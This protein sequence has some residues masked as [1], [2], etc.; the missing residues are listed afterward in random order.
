MKK[1]FL[2]LLLLFPSICY[3]QDPKLLSSFDIRVGRLNTDGFNIANRGLSAHIFT[4]SLQQGVMTSCT[5]AFQTSPNNT[6][7]TTQATGDCTS[8]G[9]SSYLSFVG[10]FIRISATT[11][12]VQSGTP[13]LTINYAGYIIPPTSIATITTAPLNNQNINSIRYAAQFSGADAW[14]KIAAAATDLPSTGGTIYAQGLEGSQSGT[15]SISSTKA[16]HLILGSGTYTYSGATV[17]I[18]LGTGSIIEGEGISSTILKVSVDGTDGINPSGNIIIRNL[19]IQGNTSNSPGS[20]GIDG[21]D[22]ANVTID[23]VEVKNWGD[24]GINT[25]NISTNWKILNSDIHDNYND[26]ILLASGVSGMQILGGRMHDNGSMGVDITGPRNQVIGAQIYNNGSRYASLGYDCNGI[27]IASIVSGAYGGS[28][29]HVTIA[30]NIIYDNACKQISSQ[31]T[32]SGT[33]NYLNIRGNTV[34][35]SAGT[36][37]IGINIDTSTGVSCGTS[38]YAVIQGNIVHGFSQQGILVGGGTGTPCIANYT[39]IIGNTVTNNVGVGVYVA[40]GTGAIITNNVILSNTAGNV[41]TGGSTLSVEFCNKTD[42]ATNYCT[43]GTGTLALD[44]IRP[45]T[46][47]GVTVTGTGNVELRLTST[48]AG[49]SDWGWFTD[50]GGTVI[51]RDYTNSANRLTIASSGLVNIPAFSIG[52]GGG[53][54]KSLVGNATLDFP[55]TSAQSSSDLTMTVTGIANG[56]PCFA[57]PTLVITVANTSYTCQ[58]TAVDTATVRFN[59]YSSGAVNPAS[60]LFQVI[61]FKQ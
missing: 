40:Y 38:N 12:T 52:S 10:N 2:A 39:S 15:T 1:I 21:C 29:D 5:I 43:A 35:V 54:T 45:N 50:S 8:G 47:A 32:N 55:N 20:S 36:P 11:F 53:L 31:A 24:H 6:T 37:L 17:A 25:G 51:W 30:D 33:V 61:G 44:S 26:G 27:Y 56:D 4:W 59:N 14:V 9:T 28:A 19:T 42:T 23:N 22:C 34:Y 7:W 13:L 57:S 48:T 58:G 18:V 41:S 46:Q 16:I 3:A 49:H 60:G